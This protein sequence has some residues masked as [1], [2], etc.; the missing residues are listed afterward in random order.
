[1]YNFISTEIIK[2]KSNESIKGR[3]KRLL[4]RYEKVKKQNNQTG[5][6]GNGLI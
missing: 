6:I 5:L 2:T 1:M 3:I 4:E